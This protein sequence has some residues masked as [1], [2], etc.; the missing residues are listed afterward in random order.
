MRR[1][2]LVTASTAALLLGALGGVPSSPANASDAGHPSA[3]KAAAGTWT[4]I[5]KTTV[6]I[7]GRSS[8]YRTTD[9]V[10]HVVY[11]RETAGG[12]ERLAY[13]TVAANGN[14][15]VQGDVLGSDWSTM[16]TSP[17]IMGDTGGGLRVVFGGLNAGY[18]GKMYTVTS[19]SA[20]STWSATSPS[21]SVGQSVSA[22]GSYGTSG[23][24]Q[25]DGTPIAAWPLN[26][27]IT[28]HVGTGAGADSSFSVAGATL[29]NT[30]MV[31]DGDS[32]W[33]SWFAYGN[34]AS[35]T[36]VFARQILPSVGPILKAPGSSEG[37]DTL[38]QGRTALAASSTG[39][40]FMAYCV[41]YVDCAKVRIW[42]VGTT[43]TVDVPKSKYADDIA[44]S[45]GPG[46]RLWL[47][48]RDNLPKVHALRTD[49]TGLRLGAN[50]NVGMPKGK[51]AVYAVAIEGSTGKG[52]VVINVGDAFWH[53][54]VL[55]G[56]TL[57]ASP[58]SWKHGGSHKVTFTVTDAGTAVS[59]AKVKVGA[60]TCQTAASGKCTIS[61]PAS[62]R[63]GK[64]TASATRSGYFK[65]TAKLKVT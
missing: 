12:G 13:A 7:I 18:A 10:L 19:D 41:G 26:S 48:W 4:K 61:F 11:P 1:Q 64:Y 46:G 45:T 49:P 3:P 58:T 16:D 23:T 8:L 47:A 24:T 14:L 40:V 5:S 63:A 21:V 34:A 53:T 37:T 39:G 38:E 35:N 54:Q 2:M 50:R 20:G 28:W 44:L 22:Y 62:T 51:A 42:K 43:R 9:K 59:G 6:G 31:R 36:G 29:Y 65:G 60:K 32:V 57:K 52:D 56:L 15:V 25:A 33:I 17:I 27:D 55:P 30:A